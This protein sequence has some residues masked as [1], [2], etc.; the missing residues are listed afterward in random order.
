[1]FPC[2][3]PQLLPQSCD[4]QYF[5]IPF[6]P[7]PHN[8][9]D[10][11]FTIVSIS[12]IIRIWKLCLFFC[13]IEALPQCHCWWQGSKS[14]LCP[15]LFSLFFFFCWPAMDVV[16]DCHKLTW[17]RALCTGLLHPFL[18]HITCLI[19]C[20]LCICKCST[21]SH[22]PFVCTHAHK[23]ARSWCVIN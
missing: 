3:R 10:S 17:G 6:F 15:F 1:M 11:F 22:G 19:K 5:I 8:S 18:K 21:C 2:K 20:V 23:R 16:W 13:T 14:F 4:F 12:C 9:S 7:P